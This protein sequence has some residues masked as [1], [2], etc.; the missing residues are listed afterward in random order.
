MWTMQWMSLVGDELVQ[1]ASV[2]PRMAMVYSKQL[3]GLISLFLVYI[4]PP[5]LLH[6]G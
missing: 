3:A 4:H 2:R 6:N 1:R 5:L